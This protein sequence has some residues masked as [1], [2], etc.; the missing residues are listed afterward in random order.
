MSYDWPGNVRELEN[1]IE[2]GVVLSSGQMLDLD[3]PVIG[4]ARV[5]TPPSVPARVPSASA[6]IQQRA[7]PSAQPAARIRARNP[8]RSK[9]W[10]DGTSWPRWS[11][12]VGTRGRARCSPAAQPHSEYRTKPHEAARHHAPRSPALSGISPRRSVA[13]RCSPHATTAGSGHTHDI[14]WGASILA[15]G[16]SK[17]LVGIQRKCSLFWLDLQQSARSTKV[18]QRLLWVWICSASLGSRLATTYPA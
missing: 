15:P 7:C 2:R 1:V 3:M 6:A 9:K 11:A 5:R 13:P 4:G 8:P 14:S 18:A 12:R 17:S 10:R 16:R